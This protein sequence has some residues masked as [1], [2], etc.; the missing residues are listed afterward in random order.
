MNI[1]SLAPSN[2]FAAAWTAFDELETMLAGADSRDRSTID[3]YG[4]LLA[5]AVAFRADCTR[6]RVGAVIIDEF[7]RIV[8]TGYNGA[9]P[10]QPGC[11]T[12]GACPRG[13]MS[14]TEVAPLSSYDTGVGACIANHAEAN[15]IMFSQ[16]ADRR[17][18]TIY[19]TDA[20]CDG[21][22]RIMNGSG[23]ARAVFPYEF[24]T[25]TAG[26]STLAIVEIDLPEFGDVGQTARI[27][28]QI[29]D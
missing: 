14:K 24:T 6:R 20:P 8:G 2:Q 21:C 25:T 15:A 12:A 1:P 13:R 19:C 16:P 4:I 5:R 28:T 22:K 18:A 3:E 9:P 29:T 10:G 23:L 7:R 17:G 26:E 27:L 11:L